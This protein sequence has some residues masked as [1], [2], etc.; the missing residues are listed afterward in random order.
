MSPRSVRVI[1]AVVAELHSGARLVRHA[2]RRVC[3]PRPPG[4]D[5]TRHL[6]SGI[7]RKKK[8]RAG[9]AFVAYTPVHRLLCFLVCSVLIV[10]RSGDRI[11]S[12]IWYQ[13][14]VQWLEAGQETAT[15]RAETSTVA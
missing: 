11:L 4:G 7:N 15:G 5:P 12:N 2:N 3:M 14:E 13:S 10:S 8:S 1:G 6:R 9:C